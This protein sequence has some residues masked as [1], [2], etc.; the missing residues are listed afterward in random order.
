MGSNP[1]LPTLF[2]Y[3]LILYSHQFPPGGTIVLSQLVLIFVFAFDVP[4][5]DLGV[6]DRIETV[7][8]L[9]CFQSIAL[10]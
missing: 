1:A 4:D 7:K 3:T 6:F 8:L 10:G 5:F 2:P 9:T